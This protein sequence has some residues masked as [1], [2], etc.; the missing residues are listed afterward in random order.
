M[1]KIVIGI[2][3]V[4]IVT[5]SLLIYSSQKEPA[6]ELSI[7][8]PIEPQNS[9]CKGT[10]RCYEEQ[11]TKIVD[12]DTIYLGVY[13]IRLSLVDT[14]ERNEKGFS[15]A[16]EFTANLCPVG[17]TVIVDQDDLQ[18]IDKYGRI[19]GKVFCGDKILNSELLENNHAGILTQYCSTS[20]FS[21]EDWAKKY[22]C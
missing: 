17:L 15:E 16:T 5:T 2:I 14:P 7:E 6:V 12:G 18:R 4:L 20:E 11:V 21:S 19:L 1:K 8:E 22:G 3:I 9:L 10:A 13:K